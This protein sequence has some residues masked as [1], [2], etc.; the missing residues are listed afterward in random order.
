[1]RTLQ[2]VF[3]F[4][5][6]PLAHQ[7]FIKACLEFN[8]TLSK[9]G[10]MLPTGDEQMGFPLELVKSINQVRVVWEANLIS[11]IKSWQEMSEERNS[12]NK[13]R[14]KGDFDEGEW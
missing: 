12:N 7:R 13:G 6:I 1:M 5:N 8:V 9:I 14:R 4:F 11:D 10:Q 2:E 3:D